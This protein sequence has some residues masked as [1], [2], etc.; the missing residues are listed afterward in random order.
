MAMT[1]RRSPAIAIV[2][3]LLAILCLI[4]AVFYW[5][6]K[7]NIL[8]SGAPAIH[9]KHALVFAG[10]TILFLL[11]AILFRPRSARYV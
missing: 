2:C 3:G 9:H 11:G 4:A 5:T 6:Q 7:T 10:L 8:S 1:T